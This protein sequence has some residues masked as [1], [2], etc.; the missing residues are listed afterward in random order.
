VWNRVQINLVSTEKMLGRKL[1]NEEI[2]D[3]YKGIKNWRE[4]VVAASIT[5]L[6]GMHGAVKSI[7]VFVYAIQLVLGFALWGRKIIP[8]KQEPNEFVYA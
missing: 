1:M 5:G 6:W 7:E 2:S 8:P 4:F 3:L